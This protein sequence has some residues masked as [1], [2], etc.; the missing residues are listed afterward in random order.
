MYGFSIFL[1]EE[2]SESTLTYMEKMANSNFRGIFTSIHIPEDDDSK[3]LARLQKLGKFAKENKMELMVDISGNALQKLGFTYEDVTPL[4]EIGLT[5]IRM[6]YGISMEM[7]AQISRKMD[8]ALNA[9]TITKHDLD[10]LKKYE[11]DFNKM[12]AW[13][14]YYPRPETGLA[15]EHFCS[16]NKWLKQAGFTVM[17]FVPG[18]GNKRGPLYKG[19]PTLE[20]QRDVHPLAAALELMKDCFVDKIYIGDPGIEESTLEQFKLYLQKK[21]LKFHAIPEQK[22]SYLHRF[23]GIHIN[24]VDDA[25]DVIRSAESRMQE[26]TRIEKEITGERPVGSIT[27]DNEKYGRYMGEM[28]ITKRDLSADE[29]VNV[30]GKIVKK[31]LSLLKYCEP[32]QTFQIEWLKGD[33]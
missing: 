6:D 3:Y 8:V 11:A 26:V 30:V 28:Q 27:I 5:G 24:R 14:N 29:K 7:I 20:K 21:T 1:N 32:G 2:V 31:D 13:H 17:S 9:S 33:F 22:S 16:Q 4:Q 19:L 23:D 15:K 10:Q 18:D 25:R 12:E